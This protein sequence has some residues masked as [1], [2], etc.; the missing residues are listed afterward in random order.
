MVCG[1]GGGVMGQMYRGLEGKA[2][3]SYG[4]SDT[5]QP[6]FWPSEL[7]N[8]L[9][10]WEKILQNTKGILLFYVCY[11]IRVVVF[12]SWCNEQRRRIMVKVK[13]FN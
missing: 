3:R 1:A 6:E 7:C 9:P 5:I 10:L 2:M 11:T 8:D 13:H 12:I 4:L